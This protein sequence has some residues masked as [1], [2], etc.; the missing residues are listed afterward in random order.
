MRS[1]FQSLGGKFDNMSSQI[2]RLATVL[3]ERNKHNDNV[4]TSGNRLAEMTLQA[5]KE[6]VA[7]LRHEMRSG[8]QS[9]GGKFDNMSSQI[10][11]LA[12]VLEERNK[13][14][15]NVETSGNRLAE[16]TLQDTTPTSSS[17]T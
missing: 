4:E 16:M 15:D 11:R 13:H 8:F 17:D 5:T 3:E 10:G 6:D 12:T 2:G 14:N 9:L 7:G 1:G